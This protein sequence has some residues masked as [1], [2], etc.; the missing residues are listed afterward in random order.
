MRHR[1]PP[2]PGALQTLSPLRILTQ[3]LLLQT[4]HYAS[5]IALIL[6]TALAAGKPF[7]LDLVLS[8]R[9]LR[10]DTTVGWTLGLCWVMCAGAGYVFSSSLLPFPFPVFQR[11]HGYIYILMSTHTQ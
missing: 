5:A 7:S 4:L 11:A 10:G 9:S 3:I 1:R 2:R 6:L 8:W